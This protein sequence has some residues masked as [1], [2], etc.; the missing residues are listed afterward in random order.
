MGGQQWDWPNAW[1][2]LQLMLMEGLAFAGERSLARHLAS[3]WLS[4]GLEAWKTTGY[5]YEKYNA[6]WPGHGGS[7]G[8]YTPQIGFGW[9]NGVAL[10]LLVDELGDDAQRDWEEDQ[11]V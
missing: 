3:E 2:P 5:M 11:F 7:G 10:S 6:T 8:E 1:P 9:S 4:T